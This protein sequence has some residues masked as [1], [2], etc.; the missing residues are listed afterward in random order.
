[1]SI[2]RIECAKCL[3]KFAE[4]RI[5]K[6]LEICKGTKGGDKKETKKTEKK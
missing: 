5:E 1:M 3:R 6:H 2:K 4:D